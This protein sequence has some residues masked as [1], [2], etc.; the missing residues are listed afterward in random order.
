MNTAEAIEAF[1]AEPAIAVVGVSQTG[2]K[3]GNV[4]C[5]TLRDKGYRV[6]PIH[7]SA[8]CIDGMRC[9]PSFSM[10]PEPVTSVLVVVRPPQAIDVMCEAAAAGARHIWLQQGAESTK[11][12]E[13]AQK[14]DVDLIVGECVLMFARPTGI[15]KLH[16]L[17]RRLVGG[18]PDQRLTA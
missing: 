16:R 10:L 18:L 11:A 3:F 12:I 17:C 9:Y 7:P 13:L 4:A 14:L 2:R 6:Y 8:S 5:R 15:H 1:L